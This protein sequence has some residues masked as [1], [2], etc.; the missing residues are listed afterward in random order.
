MRKAGFAVFILLLF[1]GFA[2]AQVPTSGNI[3]FGYSY[4]NVSSSAL[5]SPNANRASLNGW[6]GSLEGKVLPWVGIV[7][8]FGGHY[9][10]Q[11]YQVDVGGSPANATV[12][13]H[14]YTVM[15]GPRVSFQAGKFRPFVE[16]LFGI[17]H[18]STTGVFPAPSDTSFAAAIGG[19]LDYKILKPI[20]WRFEGDYLQT[21]F[22]GTTQDDVRISTGVV[23]RF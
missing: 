14:E 1:A 6:E 17:G 7:A 15:F 20:A 18:V 21:R 2:N 11:T 22:F 5:D 12:D 13:G 8:D 10:S 16:G 19:G 23:F 3:F 9:G 4:E